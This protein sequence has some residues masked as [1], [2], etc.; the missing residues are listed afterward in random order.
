MV[1]ETFKET[2]IYG[3]TSMFDLVLNTVYTRKKRDI[4]VSALYNENEKTVE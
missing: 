4:I 1:N 2:Y 3:F